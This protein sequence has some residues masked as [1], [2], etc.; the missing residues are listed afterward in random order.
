[1]HF[2]KLFALF[3]LLST[4]L[5]QTV[6]PTPINTTRPLLTLPTPRQIRSL[7]ITND[8]P[9]PAVVGVLFESGAVQYYNVTSKNYTYI[10][11]DIIQGSAGFV[12]LIKVFQIWI[13][14][15]NLGT[16]SDANAQ[17]IENRAYTIQQDG[18]V[19]RT[20]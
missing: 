5:T 20:K 18:R 3:L 11:K 19:I 8:T 4:V 7:N 9:W 2:I 6:T 13:P 10:T 14:P 17:G 16:G 15:Y 12:D 1:M